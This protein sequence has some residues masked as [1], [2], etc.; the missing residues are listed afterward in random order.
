MITDAEI[1]DAWIA[2]I[3]VHEGVVDPNRCADVA[4]MLDDIVE[5]DPERAWS[6][7]T[8][9]SGRGMSSWATENFSAGPLTT[10]VDRHGKQFAELMRSYCIDHPEF[11]DHLFG[12]VF[13]DQV[14]AILHPN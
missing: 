14:R 6:I 3:S 4:F 12:V 9:I 7:I 8:R 10:F 11:R 13:Q 5:T 1:A 2:E